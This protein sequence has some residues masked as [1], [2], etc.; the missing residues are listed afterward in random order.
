MIVLKF[1]K[2][3]FIVEV[4]MTSFL[5]F[6]KLFLREANLLKGKQ[7]CTKGNNYSA[8][9]CD[10]SDNDLLDNS[11]NEIIILYR[12]CIKHVENGPGS[13]L[14]LLHAQRSIFCCIK[15]FKRST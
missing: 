8:Q 15:V 11:N 10:T 12:N 7:L 4:I 14:D 9:D 5:F 1:H 13:H 6:C 2:N 3:R